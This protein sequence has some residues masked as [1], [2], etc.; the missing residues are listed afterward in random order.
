MSN[1]KAK[2]VSGGCP[3]KHTER[4]SGGCPVKRGGG[5]GENSGWS[6]FSIWPVQRFD[7]LDSI[8]RPMPKFFMV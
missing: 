4:S 8:Q 6:R 5:G 1:G 7:L 2:N 3:V